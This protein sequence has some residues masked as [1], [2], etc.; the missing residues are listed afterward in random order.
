MLSGVHNVRTRW[1]DVRM[2]GDG[3]SGTQAVERAL[4]ILQFFDERTPELGAAEVAER[5]GVHRSTAARLLSA[6]ERQGLVELDAATG[7]YRLGLRLVSLAGFVLNR[8]PVRS[9]ARDVLRELRDET[10]ETAYLGLLD[11][12]EVIYLDQASSPHVAVN[13]D[14]VGYRQ[15][16]TAGATGFLLL[17]FQPP[18]V[19]AE[20]VRDAAGNG[21]PRVP[22]ELELAAIRRD[23]YLIRSSPG[24]DGD[25]GV[26]AAVRDHLGATIAAVT[27]SAPGH[28]AADRLET[29]IAPAVLRAAA[30]VSERL[31]YR[32]A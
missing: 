11:G 10:E 31:G 4:S 21:G 29:V 27:V 6:L 13:V 8:F 16:L 9:L 20:L 26:A 19:I 17:A 2:A 30:R 1:Y 23:G 15:P 14:W 18:E 25:A 12:R 3:G 22:S 32:A 5:L 24:P 28:R 7:R